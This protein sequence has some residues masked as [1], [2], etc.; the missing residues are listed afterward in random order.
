MTTRFPSRWDSTIASQWGKGAVLSSPLGIGPFPVTLAFGDIDAGHPTGHSGLDLAAPL[1][2][3]LTLPIESVLVASYGVSTGG[4]LG[5]VAVWRAGELFW[6]AAHMEAQFMG[7]IGNVF[8]AG[9][10]FGT[11]GM[12][13]FTTGPHVHWMAGPDWTACIGATI[14]IFNVMRHFALD[15]ITEATLQ[16][17]FDDAQPDFYS[18]E[19][20][21]DVLE[22]A[23][24][25]KIVVP[26]PPILGPARMG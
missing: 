3:P 8:P 15:P 10:Q 22:G 6:S 23:R 26:S 2:S 16:Q 1:G 9:F 20:Q 14:P 18:V 21:P 24:T 7:T 25:V 11:V 19:D 12:T 17:I 13:G 5:N 4:Q